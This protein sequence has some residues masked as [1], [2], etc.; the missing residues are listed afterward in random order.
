MV[1]AGV[2]DPD[3]RIEL[4]DGLLVAQ[5]PQGS[6]HAVAVALVRASLERAF[7]A[8][9]HVR[10][11]K[12]LALDALSEPEPDLVVVR[13][14][15]RDYR[16]AHPS[17]PVLLVEVA[18]ASLGRDRVR[19]GRLYARAGVAEYWILNLVSEVL[20]V[21]REPTRSSPR[22]AR[23][24]SVRL[25]KISWARAQFSG[26]ARLSGQSRLEGPR[27]Q[28]VESPAHVER[29]P[30]PAR[31]RR[32]RVQVKP[33][34]LV[35]RSERPDGIVGDRRRGR[36]IGQRLSVRSP[37]PELAVGL[38]FHLVPLLVDGAVTRY[39]P[40]D[41]RTSW[42]TCDPTV[43][44][45]RVASA[46]HRTRAKAWASTPTVRNLMH[47]ARRGSAS[48]L[49]AIAPGTTATERVVT[50]RNQEQRDM[51]GKGTLVGRIAEVP[52]KGIRRFATGS[53]ARRSSPGHSSSRPPAIITG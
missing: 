32:P 53:T 41:M 13:G 38:V 1:S 49:N 22:T 17:V 27:V 12:P 33:G 20:E 51:I 3:D 6:R 48:I 23:Y 42:E 7:G 25:L 31:A 4:L 9:Y 26:Q 44:S 15:V 37:E 5:E 34:R 18:D 30:Q 19:K 28:D 24:R 29:L 35:P 46:S 16:D 2:F 21:Y 50:V 39:R 47:Q 14:R 8:G 45:G 52:W 43:I 10:E 11:E 36:D 40:I